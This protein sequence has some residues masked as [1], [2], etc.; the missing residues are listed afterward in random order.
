MGDGGMDV[1]AFWTNRSASLKNTNYIT[2][3]SRGSSISATGLVP[4]IT[5]NSGSF[6]VP[7]YAY[8]E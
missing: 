7:Y 4:Y 5:K 3:A 6:N 1:I 2:Y 8:V